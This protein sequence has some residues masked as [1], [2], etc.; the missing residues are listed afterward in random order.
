[1][2]LESAYFSFK[3]KI[4]DAGIG[5]FEYYDKKNVA[6]GKKGKIKINN[7][8]E[9][10]I[11]TEK[12]QQEGFNIFSNGPKPIVRIEEGTYLFGDEVF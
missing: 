5:E 7:K 12:I 6:L 10:E 9:I 2:H 8:N 4:D 3:G 11:Q 1:M